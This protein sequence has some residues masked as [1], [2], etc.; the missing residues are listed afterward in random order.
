MR[1]HVQLPPLSEKQRRY[2][3]EHCHEGI[4]YKCG[5]LVWCTKCGCEFVHDVPDL[6]VSIGVGDKCVCP[7]CGERLTV[8]VSTKRKIEDGYYY[9]VAT[10]IGGWQ[11]L[12]HYLVEK[13]MCR[14]SK[15]RDA[16]QKPSYQ[17]REAVQE[18]IK[19]DGKRVVVA[20]PWNSCGCGSGNWVFSK[21][22]SV[23]NER[24][25]YY[26]Y[27]NPYRI[28]AF[29]IYPW[30]R[31]LP[32]LKRNGLRG[33]WPDV[34]PSELM[35]KLL[36]DTRAETLMK[37]GQWEL[38]RYLVSM[39]GLTYWRQVLIAIRN[40]YVVENVAL[41]F[42]LL[43][44]LEYLGKDLHNAHYVCP[45]NLKEAHDYW[46]EK[47]RRLREKREAVK[48]RDEAMYWE[49]HYRR[50]KKK[51][52]GVVIREGRIVIRPIQSV[53][54]MQEEGD[55]MHHCVAVN[56]YYKKDESLILSAKNED[57]DRLE[58]IEVSLKT[59]QVVQCFGKFNGTTEYHSEILGMMKR[60]MSKIAECV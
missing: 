37:T 56:G 31:V 47:K 32:I 4:G 50:A 52:L 5:G 55:A 58:T 23:K 29:L 44:A 48:K 45:E 39:G 41:W 1:L 43:H 25:G 15:Y 40:H 42:D 3:E 16:R 8:K 34:T 18:W 12:R 57:G 2:A 54:E 9:T 24:V 59:M 10:T 7:M 21:P 26:S 35:I 13:W 22:M 38:L 33:E 20:R 36:T 17:V 46:I 6:G 27:S 28:Y 30:K 11:V 19:E 49:E 53:K 51:F 14:V 60:N